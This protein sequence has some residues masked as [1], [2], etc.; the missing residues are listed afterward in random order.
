MPWFEMIIVLVDLGFQGIVSDY[1][2]DNIFIPFKKP[3]KSK[4]KPDP[5]LSADQK[6]VNKALAQIRVLAENAIAGIKRFNI[7]TH[8]FRNSK[9]DFED[10]VIAV[11]AGLWNFWL[12]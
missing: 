10:E 6:A 7:L 5:K 3:R 2:G 9:D 12:A 11:S 1:E 4:L 8:T